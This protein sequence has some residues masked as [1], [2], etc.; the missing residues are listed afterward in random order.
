MKK[1]LLGFSA[2]LLSAAFF[3]CKK[4]TTP[5]ITEDEIIF[6]RTDIPEG[7]CPP[8]TVQLTAGQYINAGSVSVTSDAQY[9]YVT[10]STANGY[11]LTQTHLYVGNCSTIPVNTPGNPIPGQFPYNT[12]HAYVNSFTY[13]IP[14]SAIPVGS[15]GCVAAHAVV[16]KLNS[17][18]QVI[19]Q[20]TGW[21]Q[22]TVINPSGSNWGMKFEYC[23]CQ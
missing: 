20:Q 8:T 5:S 9:L 22:G 15:C 17:S 21:G 2:I 12:N 6:S 13:Q 19:E 10:Y 1:T 14:I 18:G 16:V 23:P 7:T 4:D 3:S 11:L